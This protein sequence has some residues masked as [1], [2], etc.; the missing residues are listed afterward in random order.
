[1]AK[2][3]IDFNVDEIT[4]CFRNAIEEWQNDAGVGEVANVQSVTPVLSGALKKSI[5]F[6]KVNTKTKYTLKIGSRLIYSAKVEYKNKSYIRSTLSNDIGDL[7]TSLLET[8]RRHL[9]G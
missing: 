2:W 1:M 9:N 4:E 6:K 3:I 7:K 5:T 8:I